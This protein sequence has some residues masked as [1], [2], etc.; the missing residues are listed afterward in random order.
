MTN[1]GIDQLRTF[2]LFLFPAMGGLLF[3]EWPLLCEQTHLRGIS[4]GWMP[5]WTLYDS[6]SV[7]NGLINWADR[8]SF[9]DVSIDWCCCRL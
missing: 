7:G 4:R 2:L 6:T 1:V 8:K 5:S 3:G 9:Q